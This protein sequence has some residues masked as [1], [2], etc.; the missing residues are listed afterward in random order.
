VIVHPRIDDAKGANM[1]LWGQTYFMTE[2]GLVAL[3]KTD[4]ALHTV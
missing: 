3:N 1:L 4:A 2:Q